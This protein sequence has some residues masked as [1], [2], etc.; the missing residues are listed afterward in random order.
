MRFYRQKIDFAAGLLSFVSLLSLNAI[1]LSGQDEGISDEKISKEHIDFFESKIRPVLVKNCYGCHSA[2]TG[3]ARGGLMLDTKD[4]IRAGG[5]SGEGVLPGDVGEG[6]ILSAIN[7]EDWEMPPGRPLANH[8]IDDIRAW[9]AMG[10]P[11]PRATKIGKINSTITDRD[12]EAAKNDFW[13]YQSPKMP[14]VPVASDAKWPRNSIDRFVL[15]KLTENELTP[16]VDTDAETFLRRICVDL[17]GLPPSLEQLKWFS[18]AWKKDK[19]RAIQYV[20]QSLL[21]SDRFGERWGRHWLDVARYAESSGK[22]LNSTFENAWRYRDYV[23]DAF[24]NDKPYDEFIREQIAGDLIPVKTDE[25]WSEHLIATGFLALGPKTLSE[26]NPRQ[27]T[28]DLIDEQIDTTTRVVLG[29][30]VAC[31]RCHDHKFDPIPQTDYYAMAG[32][33]QSTKTYF[34][35]ASLGRNRRPTS[36]IE[37]PVADPDPKAKA[38]SRSEIAKMKKERDEL[39]QEYITA[40]RNRRLA[41]RGQLFIDGKKVSANDPRISFQKIG[42]TSAQIAQLDSKMKSVDNNGKPASYCMGVQTA[43]SPVNSRLL[44]RGELSKPAQEIPRGLVQVLSHKEQKI[45]RRSSGRLELANWMTEKANPLTARVM[46]NRIWQH[47]FGEG[48]VSTP[49]NFGATG[50]FPTH[51]ELLDYLAVKFME[52]DWS[53]KSIITEIVQSRAYRMSSGFDKNK[54][55]IDPDNRF[56][57]RANQR[58]IDAEVIRDSLLFVAGNINFERPRGSQVSEIAGTVR[59]LRPDA[60]TWDESKTYRSVYLPVMRD[61]LP[62]VLAVFDFAE[63]SMVIGK[64]DTSNTPSQALYMLNNPFVVQQSEKLARRIMS[65]AS[66]VEQQIRIALQL[67][68]GRNPTLQETASAKRFFQKYQPPGRLQRTRDVAALAAFCQALFASAEFRFLN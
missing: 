56:L 12:I 34:G 60:M 25:E 65:E 9:I 42:R 68:Y 59:G 33:F 37:L 17:V 54:F 26:Q 36:L 1:A 13:A 2:K 23:I 41:A 32:I 21:D 40:Q 50:Q 7:Y 22:E 43:D 28:A 27:F 55:E 66:Q 46:V 47:L 15:E 49:E 29:M 6:T 45:G 53:I 3:K 18:E 57:W 11:D 16:T 14:D 63:P 38:I 30:S 61:N 44:I 24:N 20:T 62:R 10:A 5:D 48:I 8:E 39:E 51:P 19:D 31:A 67:T 58:R 4:G 64:R 35:T 52:S